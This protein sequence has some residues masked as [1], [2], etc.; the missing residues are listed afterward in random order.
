MFR[1]LSNGGA[2]AHHVAP[3]E[4][5]S[6]ATVIGL[7][8]ADNKLPLRRRRNVASALRLMAKAAGG[9]P[10]EIPAN[11]TVLRSRT[12]GFHPEHARVSRKRWQNAWSETAFALKHLGL[13]GT[14]TPLWV[15][16]GRDW[17]RLLGSMCEAGLKDWH[18]GRLARC[19][20]ARGIGPEGVSDATLPLYR[21]ALVEESRRIDP[22]RVVR[23]T[24]QLWNKARQLV[25][26]WPAI[27]LMFSPPEMM[28][29]FERSRISI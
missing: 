15:P 3:S 20:S 12:A 7:I 9:A 27:E 24:A 22:E 29:S 6:L 14:G 1:D 2:H 19:F 18:L 25:P 23:R 17:Q 13:T 11:I 4:T 10:E 16:L 21:Q 8:M 28:T 5:P 26:G